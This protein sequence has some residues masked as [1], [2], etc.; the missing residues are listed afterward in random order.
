VWRVIDKDTQ[1]PYALKFFASSASFEKEAFILR[2]IKH[3]ALPELLDAYEEDE[4][5][6]W[7]PYSIT[8][9]TLGQMTLY[10]H[11]RYQRPLRTTR[12]KLIMEDVLAGVEALHQAGYS[13]T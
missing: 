7:Y 9:T 13:T 1:L 4:E 11:A 6:E 12:I 5:S 10:D 2:T 3:I 8:V